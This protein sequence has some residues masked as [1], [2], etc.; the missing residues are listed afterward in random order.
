LHNNQAGV[1]FLAGF[2]IEAGALAYSCWTGGN[3]RFYTETTNTSGGNLIA[4]FGYNAYNFY[5]NTNG[6]STIRISNFNSG[7]D[8]HSFI[9]AANKTSAVT[10]F[11]NS[12]TRTV[13]S[14]INIAILRNDAGDLR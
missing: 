3:H 4:Q 5:G 11:L 9:Q 6:G 10:L 1:T 14:G 7:S 8:A 13:D 2:G 12:S